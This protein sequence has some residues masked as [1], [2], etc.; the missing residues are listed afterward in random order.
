MK[1]LNEIHY[2][3]NPK[4]GCKRE[5]HKVKTRNIEIRIKSDGWRCV[6]E[7]YYAKIDVCSRCNQTLSEPYE[8][9]YK[10]YWT[11][12]SMPKSR[13]DELREKGYIII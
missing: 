12:V 11:S 9:E 13:W 3:I 7:D 10:T 5:G 1:I 6:A 8:K 4:L 2:F